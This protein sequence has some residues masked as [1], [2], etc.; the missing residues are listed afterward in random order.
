MK[1][2]TTESEA[3]QKEQTIEHLE[4]AML[5]IDES[6]MAADYE[7]LLTP[8]DRRELQT[9]KERIDAQSVKLDEEYHP[10]SE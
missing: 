3:L 4:N 9:I 10:A 7:D 1:S 5:E 8:S 2:V 6:I